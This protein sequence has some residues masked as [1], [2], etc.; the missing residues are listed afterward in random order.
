MHLPCGNSLIRLEHFSQLVR[1]VLFSI[2]CSFQLPIEVPFLEVEPQMCWVLREDLKSVSQYI[3]GMC[4]G[5]LCQQL[6]QP[7]Q[8]LQELKLAETSQSA[9]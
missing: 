9:P 3:I 2:C 5:P 7:S 8:Q 1:V 6:G 4:V